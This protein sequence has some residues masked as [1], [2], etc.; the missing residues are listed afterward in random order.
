MLFGRISNLLLR[1]F[2]KLFSIS[3][4]KFGIK[5]SLRPKGLNENILFQII[6]F[7]PQIIKENALRLILSVIEILQIVGL[8]KKTYEKDSFYD[9]TLPGLLQ[10]HAGSIF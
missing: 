4:L 9:R 6:R 2:D 3:D 8:N 7:P 10:W 1:K 5:Q